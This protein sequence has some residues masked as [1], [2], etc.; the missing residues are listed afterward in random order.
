MT[1]SPNPAWVQANIESLSRIGGAYD[2][3]CLEVERIHAE[4]LAPYRLDTGAKTAI[5]LLR[6]RGHVPH[7][8]ND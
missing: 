4:I 2:F 5:E 6:E 1:T 3:V 8:G 7:T